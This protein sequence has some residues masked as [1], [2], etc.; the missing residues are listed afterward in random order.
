MIILVT[1]AS[2]GLG[3]SIAQLLSA[4]NDVIGCARSLEKPL[5]EFK[6]IGGI[7]LAKPETFELLPLAEIDAIVNNAA[8]AADGLLATQ[9]EDTIRNL[10]DVNLLGTLLLTKRWVRSRLTKQKS[11]IIVN[12]SSIIGIRGYSGLAT[13]S[14]TKAGL[15]GVTRALAREL[16]P[17]KFR[18]NSIQPG[19][20]ETDMSRQLNSSQRDQIIRRTPLGRLATPDDIASAV[21]FLLS[22][23][24][25][26]ITGQCLTVDGGICV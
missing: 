14:A 19:Y 25:A 3:L 16:G 8:I 21:K 1:G 7:D 9:S 13:Y 5:G 11:G 15:D 2:K 12:I 26:F 22:P 18:V 23:D 10:I 6:Y 4:S 20:V 17:K 24:A